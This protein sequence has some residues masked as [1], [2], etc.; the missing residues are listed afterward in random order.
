VGRRVSVV[1]HAH[2]EF[3]IDHVGKDSWRHRQAGAFE[4]VVA[5]DR[6]LAKMRE[7]ERTQE[8]TID[9]LL[10][11]LTE[12][13]WV[14]VEGFRNSPLPKIETWRASLGKAVQYPADPRIIA[15]A[16]D[17]ARLLPHPTRL[18]VLDLNDIDAIADFVLSKAHRYVYPMAWSEGPTDAP[19]F[20]GKI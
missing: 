18:P 9:E 15:I 19:A 2:H 6:R 4:V 1:K 8:P 10:A 16:T 12:C 20:N 17:D 13:D 14:L 11:E 5:S 3:D 7:Y